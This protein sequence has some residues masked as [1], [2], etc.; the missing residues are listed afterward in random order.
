MEEFFTLVNN[1]S[2]QLKTYRELE[3]GGA[4]DE[5]EPVP[6]PVEHSCENIQH[7]CPFTM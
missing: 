2:N 6:V 1:I 7:L 5:P 4:Q 3:Y